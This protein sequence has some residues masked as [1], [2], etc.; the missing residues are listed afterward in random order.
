[1]TNKEILAELKTN[2]EYLYDI[3]ENSYEQLNKEELEKL[4]QAEEL[5]DE[6]YFDFWNR[7]FSS[8]E[9]LSIPKQYQDTEKTGEIILIGNS[10]SADYTIQSENGN[11][12]ESIITCGDLEYYWYQDRNFIDN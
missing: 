4:R 2:Y 6:V 1:M 12:D 8:T 5:I 10:P 3:R 7:L 9:D 11:F